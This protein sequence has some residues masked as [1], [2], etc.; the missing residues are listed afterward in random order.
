MLLVEYIVVKKNKTNK[1]MIKMSYKKRIIQYAYLLTK[2]GALSEAQ[3]S[4]LLNDFK[5]KK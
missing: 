3:K 5:Q 4:Q 1:E 2:M